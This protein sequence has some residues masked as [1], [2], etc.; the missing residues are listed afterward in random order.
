MKLIPY[1]NFKMNA[2]EAIN[3]Y[4]RALNGQIISMQRYKDSPME[5]SEE[6]NNK[7]MHAEY[8]FNGN[9]LYF[10][11]S[12]SSNAGDNI[13]LSIQCGSEE[14]INAI[15]NTLSEGGKIIMPLQDTFWG[16]KFGSFQDIYDI[17]WLLN[18]DKSESK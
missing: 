2:E 3:F 12:E 15:Y 8:S 6:M 14:E 4:H 13:A 10:S 5:V 17:R 11:D 18:Y 9:T 1:L 7:V 16:A